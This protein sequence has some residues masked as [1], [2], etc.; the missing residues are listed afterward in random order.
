MNISLPNS[1]TTKVTLN[2]GN[3][4]CVLQF[5]SG[6]PVTEGNLFMHLPSYEKLLT[7]VNGAYFLII[8]VVV[9]GATWT[10]CKLGKRKRHDGV[11][12]QELEM[13]LP[14]SVS[15]TDVETAEG[16]DQGWD[17]DWDEDT[18]AKSSVKRHVGSISA[19][20]LT[21]RSSNKDGWEDN[22]DD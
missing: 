21:S 3:G 1:G 6:T 20:G 4:D 8:S 11:P 16:W 17:D 14:E 13:A 15:A 5:G 22:W 12:Y 9:L 19:N 7:P 2:A 10:C 18:E